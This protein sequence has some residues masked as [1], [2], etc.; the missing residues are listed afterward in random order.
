MKSK[1]THLFVV[2]IVSF[3]AIIRCE[4]ALAIG[5]EAAK[6]HCREKL[7]PIVQS[8][9]RQQ[10]LAKGGSPEHYVSGC[11]DQVRPQGKECVQKLTG[12]TPARGGAGGGGA[13]YERGAGSCIM[14]QCLVHGDRAL[15]SGRRPSSD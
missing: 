15:R 2:L 9:V 10:V 14:T 13:M 4:S 5:M 8:C 1:C 7:R 11:K 6:N 3:W 12:R